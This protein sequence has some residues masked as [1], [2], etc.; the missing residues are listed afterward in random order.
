MKEIPLTQGKV[1]RVD[2][3]DYDAVMEAGPWSAS[4]GRT[5]FYAM[6]QS[7]SMHRFI[8]GLHVRGEWGDHKNHNG[9]D[10]QSDNLRSATPTQNNQHR[11]KRADALHSQYKGVTYDCRRLQSGKKWRA[12]I[13][14]GGKRL[15][16][17]FDK[18][19]DAALDYNIAAWL[20]Y[21]EFAVLN[22][23]HW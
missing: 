3:A 13:C 9:L 8:L 11:R 14:I 18:E 10:N 7:I 6:H 12:Q 16:W 23:I 4:K 22:Q 17:S 20:A 2:D 19:T 21:G 15:T 5:T 1:A